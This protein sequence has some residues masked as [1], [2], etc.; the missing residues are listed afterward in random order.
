MSP[1]FA[2]GEPVD[3]IKLQIMQDEINALKLD[4][5][6]AYSLNQTTSEGLAKLVNY[7]IKAGVATFENGLKKGEN[8]IGITLNWD[9]IFQVIYTVATPRLQRPWVNNV[10]W[11]FSGDRD[12]T[13]LNVYAEKEVTGSVN[14]HWI[15]V[16]EKESI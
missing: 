9:P 3:P 6:A 4:T 16:G 7:Q 11:S 14:F 8:K 12:T 13:S 10:R 5:K 2:D 15:S 1:I